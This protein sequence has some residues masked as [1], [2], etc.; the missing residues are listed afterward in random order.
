MGI[1]GKLAEERRGQLAAE[2][3]LE[4]KQEELFAANRK[5]GRHAQALSE[6]IVETRA[7]ISTVRSKTS[8]SNPI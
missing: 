7:E 3:L 5:L 8:R 1:S 2:R 6:E 4:L